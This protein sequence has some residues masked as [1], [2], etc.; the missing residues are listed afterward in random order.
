MP[1]VRCSRCGWEGLD[2]DLR[3]VHRP[4]P[5]DPTDVVPESGCPACL[6][7]QHLEYKEETIVIPETFSKIADALLEAKQKLEN[8]ANA[9]VKL[10]TVL[11]LTKLEEELEKHEAER[12]AG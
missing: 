2:K 5:V 4:N 1:E 6:S 9:L 12:Q 8:L 7:Y 10:G 3:L 11:E